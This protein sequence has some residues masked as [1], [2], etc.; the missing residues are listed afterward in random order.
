MCG[1]RGSSSLLREPYGDSLYTHTRY[2][3]VESDGINIPSILLHRI[4]TTIKNR[5]GRPNEDRIQDRF[6]GAEKYGELM[7]PDDF[8][9]YLRDPIYNID[10]RC[11]LCTRISRYSEYHLYLYLV[12]V[13]TLQSRYSSVRTKARRIP[14]NTQ[15]TRWCIE[16]LTQ[17]GWQ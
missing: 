17:R 12:H 9:T 10:G 6:L 8:T 15:V 5:I 14:G 16:Y 7:K 11:I 2:R 4:S 1:L 3:R 13:T